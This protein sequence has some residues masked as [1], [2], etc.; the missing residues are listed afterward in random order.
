MTTTEEKLINSVC[1]TKD[2]S[3]LMDTDLELLGPWKG[4]WEDARKYY[5]RYRSIPDITVLQEKYPQL[6]NLN[7]KG[8]SAHYASTLRAEFIRSRV[9]VLMDKA[10]SKF[11]DEQDPPEKILAEFQAHLARLNKYTNSVRDLDISDYEQAEKRIQA[12]KE[13]A[14]A[15]GGRVG[16]NTGVDFVD[17]AYV[18]GMAPGHLIVIIGWPGKA[19]TWGAGHIACNAYDQGFKPMIVSL[20]MTPENMADRIYTMMGSGLFSA[21]G[22]AMGDINTDDFREFAQKRFPKKNRFAI[23]SNDGIHDVTPNIIQGKIEQHNPDLV[24]LDYAQLMS[25]NRKSDGM[26][27]RMMNLSREVKNMAVTNG[28]PVI[29]I[30]AA[31]AEELSDRDEP[32]MLSSV[33][34]SKSIEYDA[35]MAIAIHKRDESDNVEWV[36]R[37]NR[38]GRLFDGILEWEIDSGVIKTLYEE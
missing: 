4:V 18:T 25:D 23:V 34:W 14:D 26:T 5:N 20:E 19:K 13:R 17:Q 15:M 22:F 31:T 2:V 10:E 37:K 12:T 6:D 32:P 28:I 1:E 29:L 8:A 35:D 30:T 3:V 16:I 21:S 7:V 33:A 27:P 24:I 9:T 36:C 11:Q 38:H